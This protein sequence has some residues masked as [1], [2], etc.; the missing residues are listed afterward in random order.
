LLVVFASDRGLHLHFGM[1]GR[2][3]L[4]DQDEPLATHARL[5][6]DLDDEHRIIFVDTRMFGRIDAGEAKKLR[7]K[8]FD[9]LGRDP[10][11]DPPDARSLLS[12]LS[13]TKRPVKIALLDQTLLAGIGNIQAAEALFFARIHPNIRSNALSLRD[14]SRLAKGIARALTR[15][16]AHLESQGDENGGDVEYLQDGAGNP[17]VVYGRAGERCS[18]C[19]K[20]RIARTEQGQRATYFCPICQAP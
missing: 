7:A 18:R 13:R 20:G 15:E 19:R 9:R 4:R 10:W 8:V 6:L 17:F 5:A 11:L 16:L 1:S 14:A 12:I 3:L 2:V